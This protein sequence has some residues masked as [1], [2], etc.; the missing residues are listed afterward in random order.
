MRHL[1][2]RSYDMALGAIRKYY[3]LERFPQKTLYAL[4]ELLPKQD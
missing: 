2:I 1:D 3:P 4:A